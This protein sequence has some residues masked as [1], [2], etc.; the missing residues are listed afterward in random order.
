MKFAEYQ[1]AGIAHYWIPDLNTGDGEFEAFHQTAS[2][3]QQFHV[4]DGD[5]VSIAEPVTLRFTLAELTSR[6]R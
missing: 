6:R 2:G 1:Q 3:Y 4:L 5:T